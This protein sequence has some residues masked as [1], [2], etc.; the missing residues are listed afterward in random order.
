MKR[1]EDW[2]LSTLKEYVK[3]LG[4]ELEVIAVIGDKRLRLRGLW[5]AVCESSLLRCWLLPARLA[6]LGQQR[7]IEEVVDW[8]RDFHLFAQ[9]DDCPGLFI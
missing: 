8:R 2:L 1:R 3:A 5:R 9:A 6:L 7:G 4:G